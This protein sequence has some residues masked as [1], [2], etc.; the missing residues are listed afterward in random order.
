M[1]KPASQIGSNIGWLQ[2]GRVKSSSFKSAV[3]LLLQGD[4]KLIFSYSLLEFGALF[5]DASRRRS[6]VVALCVRCGAHP[7]D[8]RAVLLPA[9]ALGRGSFCR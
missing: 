4:T 7:K 9:V 5:S 6:L 1:K 2:Q 8:S 3:L